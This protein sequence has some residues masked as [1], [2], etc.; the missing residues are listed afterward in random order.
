ML[1]IAFGGPRYK[2]IIGG[3]WPQT[4]QELARLRRS[5]SAL[6]QFYHRG[7]ATVSASVH[8]FKDYFICIFQ[9]LVM[10]FTG[11]FLIKLHRGEAGHFVKK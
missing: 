9:M 6:P 7:D 3:T 5:F 11:L 8:H 1:K 4:S 10:C 2:K